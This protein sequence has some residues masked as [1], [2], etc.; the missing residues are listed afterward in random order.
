MQAATGADDIPALIPLMLKELALIADHV[1]QQEIER[2]RAQIRA[3]LLMTHE[4]PAA[5]AGQIA[6]QMML[7]GRTI[8]N[9]ELME[10]LVNITPTRLTD[11]AGRLFFDEKITLSA[12][13]PIDQLAS[14]QE[15]EEQLKNP[16]AMLG[17][18]Q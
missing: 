18:A 16:Q 14:L 3:G 10:R 1:D 9:E 4:S 11:L 15:I 13:G 2:A 5:R 6:R 17:A 12:V 8:P 7:F